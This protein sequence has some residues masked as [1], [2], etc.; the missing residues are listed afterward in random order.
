MMKNISVEDGKCGAHRLNRTFR[1]VVR[2]VSFL[3]A[4]RYFGIRAN[5]SLCQAPC[6]GRRMRPDHLTPMPGLRT[7][8]II[9]HG[10]QKRAHTESGVS[11]GG[12]R[13]PRVR[14]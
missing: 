3:A 5:S 4:V 14:P 8:S 11:N 12:S 2:Q 13:S 1:N 6:P 9:G 10:R 7:G